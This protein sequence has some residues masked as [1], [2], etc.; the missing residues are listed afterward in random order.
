MGNQATTQAAPTARNCG[1]ARDSGTQILA[2]SVPH[3]KLNPL[4]TAPYDEAHNAAQ[5]AGRR[6]IVPRSVGRGFGRQCVWHQRFV[7]MLRNDLWNYFV[8]VE[9]DLAACQRY[10]AFDSRN[11]SAHSIEFAKI[12]LLAGAETD[13]VLKELV[14]GLEPG[15]KANKLPDYERAIETGLP[16]FKG[17]EVEI[18]GT[19]LVLRPWSDWNATRGPEWW[20]GSYNKL[21]HQRS[22]SFDTANLQ[23]ALNA[24]GALYVALLHLHHRKV[25]LRT[26]RQMVNSTMLC[27]P[28]NHPEDARFEY[29]FAG[30]PYD[31]F[32][33]GGDV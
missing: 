2:L 23:S 8:A 26:R 20:S 22:K 19:E 24:V 1:S 10:V 7:P 12:I 11:L 31:F 5:P 13:S 17:L 32:E 6:N 21:K 9:S 27:R 18:K 16:F 28:R 3:D 15:S 14:R 4:Y 33:P 29:A 30:S 25:D